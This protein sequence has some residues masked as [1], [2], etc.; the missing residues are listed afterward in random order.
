MSSIVLLP[1]A[2]VDLARQVR[3]L[4]NR[5]KHVGVR[6]LRPTVSLMHELNF[7][8]VDVVDITLEVERFF[9]LTIPDQIPLNTVGDLLC[10]VGAHR[11]AAYQD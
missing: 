11:P 9:H 7:D 2:S 6:Q 5:R 1:G 10:Y 4:S 8:L 3:H